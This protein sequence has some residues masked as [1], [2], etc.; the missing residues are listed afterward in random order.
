MVKRI[1]FLSVLIRLALISQANGASSTS[2]IPYLAEQ[3]ININWAARL[4]LEDFHALVPIT[5]PDHATLLTSRTQ[6]VVARLTKETSA[7]TV[8]F[9][10]QN[11]GNPS[12][13]F[14]FGTLT[15]A[16]S[17]K[18]LHNILRQKRMSYSYYLR[19]LNASLS[20]KLNTLDSAEKLH[21]LMLYQAPLQHLNNEAALHAGNLPGLVNKVIFTAL[22]CELV[23]IYDDVED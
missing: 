23:P 6:L 5:H 21:A 19:M 22:M 4:S 9:Y 1:L 13:S 8:T 12:D 16:C 17:I 15:V 11:P 14:A 10:F 20:E 18:Q 3:V 2:H 7:C